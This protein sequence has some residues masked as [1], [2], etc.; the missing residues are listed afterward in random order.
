MPAVAPKRICFVTGTRAEF[1]LMRSTLAAITAHRHLELQLVVT[2]M[3]LSRRHGYTTDEVRRGGWQIDA[4]VPW[5][6]SRDAA[7]L[8]RHTGATMGRLATA[9]ERLRSDVV[10]VVGDRVEAF[11]AASAGLVAQRAVAHVHGGDRA[12][13]QIDDALR[14]AITKLAHV[15]FPA[16]PGSAERIGRLG[17]DAW[18]I[19]HVG[20]P[21]IDGIARLATPMA[22]LRTAFPGLR[23]GQFA[24]IALHPTDASGAAEYD[25]ALAVLSAV[26]SAGARQVVVVYPNNDPG[27]GEIVRCWQARR[28]DISYLLPDVPRAHFVGLMRHCGV[29]VGNSSAGIIEA[30]ALGTPVVNVGDRQAG[31]ERGRN[32]VDVPFEP[33][34][35]AQAAGRAMSSPRGGTPDKTHPY[36]GGRAGV[37]IANVLHRLTIDDRLLRKLI[38]Y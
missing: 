29:M 32:V 1:G 16:T 31:R 38:A 24:L 22:S 36:G 2:G 13:G 5:P 12:A 23:S 34:A 4:T 15:H 19:H 20:A 10:L 6:Q 37:S 27:A 21:G 28:G 25:R 3:H 17:E 18:R 8:A 26:R 11:A 9:F 35:I 30:G 14:H 7:A 33:T